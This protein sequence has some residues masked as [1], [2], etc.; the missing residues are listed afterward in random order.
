MA[1]LI[2]IAMAVLSGAMYEVGHALHPD[3]AGEQAQV[4][5]DNV[6]EEIQA[7]A[8]HDPSMQAKLDSV[9]TKTW[10]QNVT[11]DNQTATANI[12]VTAS[13]SIAWIDVTVNGASARAFASLNAH[14][15]APGSVVGG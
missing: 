15:V 1:A 2:A 9:G 6:S 12:T 14:S 4:L 11:V 5:A 7:S 8:S 10:T 13:G 3:Y